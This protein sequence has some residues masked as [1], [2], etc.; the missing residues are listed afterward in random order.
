VGIMPG[1][2]QTGMGHDHDV[3]NKEGQALSSSTFAAGLRWNPLEEVAKTVMVLC[4][5]GMDTVNGA[6]VTTDNG[7]SAI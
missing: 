7:W 2:M 4:S 3:Y 1:A 6:I 5:E